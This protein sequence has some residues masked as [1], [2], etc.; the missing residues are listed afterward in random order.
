MF[1]ELA[2]LLEIHKKFYAAAHKNR[3]E[4]AQ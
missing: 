2:R 4:R 3:P 1:K